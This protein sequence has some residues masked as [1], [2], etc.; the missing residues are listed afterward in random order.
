MRYLNLIL[1][2]FLIVTEALFEGLRIA[3]LH[4][5]AE[6]TELVYLVVVT[7][8][9]FAYF[10]RRIVREDPEVSSFG[11]II[12]GYILLRFAVFDLVFNL[13]A[14]L[15]WNYIGFTKVT[16]EILLW[17]QG[18]WGYSPIAFA[19][20]IAGIWGTAWLS[21]WQDGIKGTH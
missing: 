1:A 17:I 10:N 14:G 11:K 12:I 21:G 15:A 7:L 13:S 19:K 4:T 6:L 5:W 8:I 16:D 20:I 3:D 9:A 2:V 18:L